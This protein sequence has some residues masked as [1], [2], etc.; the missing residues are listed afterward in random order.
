MIEH[1]FRRGEGEGM[2]HESTSEE[3]DAGGRIRVVAVAPIAAVERVHVFRAPRDRA[4]GQAAADDLAIRRDVRA[5]AEVRLCARGMAAEAG[6][7]FVEDQGDALLGGQCAQGVEKFAW[8]QIRPP[9]LHPGSTSTAKRGHA[10]ERAK[11]LERLRI[12]VFEHEHIRDRALRD[13]GR[14]RHRAPFAID[15]ERADERLVVDAVISPGEKRDL[16]A[17]RDSARDTDRP[18]HGLRAGIAKRRALHAD[19]RAKTL[20]DL[21]GERRGRGRFPSRAASARLDGA[22]HEVGL[23]AE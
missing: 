1:G 19:E 15:D 2:A 7:H 23:M 5:D 9:A 17:A 13:A 20:R 11:F 6:D 16:V 12:A 14:N 8:L 10:R 22:H 21:A 3:G 4:D 18:Q